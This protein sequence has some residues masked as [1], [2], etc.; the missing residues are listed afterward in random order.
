MTYREIYENS[1]GQK[2]PAGFDI[3]HLDLN[4]DNNEIVNLLMLPHDLH[5]Q[6]HDLESKVK[7]ISFTT[8]ILSMNEPGYKSNSFAFEHAE[9]FIKV[10]FECQKWKDYK[11]FL[12]GNLPNIHNIN[13]K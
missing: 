12:L 1:T 4:H 13:L 10:Y 6:Y 11:E 8:S 5:I 2:I 3:H 7:S 9:K